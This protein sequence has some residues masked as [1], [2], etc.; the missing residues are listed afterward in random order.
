MASEATW[1]TSPIATWI[2]FACLRNL[3]LALDTSTPMTGRSDHHQGQAPV[4]P[5]QV[6][7]QEDDGQALADHHLDGVGG[8]PRHHGDVEGDARDEVAG[9]AAVVVA[10][11]QPQQAVEEG[12]AQVVHHAHRDPRE[13]VVAEEGADALPGGD[14]HDQQRDGD[15]EVER[16][17][18][19]QTG[20]DRRI[21]R[22]KAVDEVLEHARQP[23]LAC[24]RLSAPPPS[25][26][27]LPPRPAAAP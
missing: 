12:H 8:G 3:R 23:G 25:W 18:P 19:G 27:P 11:G 14:Q 21:G 7:E 2:F 17:E 20:G 24:T 6:A 9:I 5:E 22:G 10:V 1:V 4:H 15:D 26:R 16:I 13:E